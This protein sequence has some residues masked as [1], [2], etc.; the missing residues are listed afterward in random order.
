MITLETYN[1][2]DK[3]R[4]RFWSKVAIKGHNDCWEWLAAK[5]HDFGYGQYSVD[6]GKRVILAHRFA[7]LLTYGL[8]TDD[9]PV[10]RHSCDNPDCCNPSHL[11]DGTIGDN[12]A[13]MVLRNRYKVGSQN[14]NSVLDEV[15][16]SLIRK[17]AN[18][19]M[20]KRKEL[21]NMFG[22]SRSTIY[23][24]VNN[25]GWKHI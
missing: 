11:L 15:R 18:K 2:I 8:I 24:I 4:E 13:D 10:I 3:D 7:Y 17:M 22:V 21:A 20:Y 23:K 9:K 16:V 6:G 19:P 14:A 25:K 12:N 5:H 1:F